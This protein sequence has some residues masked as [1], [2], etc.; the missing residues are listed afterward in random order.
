MYLLSVSVK[1]YLRPS[2]ASRLGL[3]QVCYAQLQCSLVFVTALFF[4]V[5]LSLSKEQWMRK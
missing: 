4:L 3:T 5:D 2:C 1:I